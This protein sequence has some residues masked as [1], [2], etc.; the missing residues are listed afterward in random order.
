[1]GFYEGL[2]EEKY[3]RQY[4]DRDLAKRIF[5]HFTAQRK[6]VA[7]IVVLTV[8]LAVITTA[9]PVIISQGLNRLTTMPSLAASLLIGGIVLFIG[10]A[11]W[12]LNWA[13]R[14]LTVRTVGDVVLNLRT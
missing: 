12:G 2:N 4:K 3:D 11:D 10:V 7:V 13:R 5:D 1:M 6:R 14:R 8:S 9:Q